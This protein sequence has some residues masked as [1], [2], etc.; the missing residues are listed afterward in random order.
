M[1]EGLNKILVEIAKLSRRNV[2]TLDVAEKEECCGIERD[3]DGFCQHR[4]THPI[5]VD[6]GFFSS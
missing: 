3:E 4:P 5:Y 1:S 6:L 2:I